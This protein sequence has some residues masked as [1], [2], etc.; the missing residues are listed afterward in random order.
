MMYKTA[1]LSGAPL[2]LESASDMAK[3]R[4]AVS[5]Q[6]LEAFNS[7]IATCKETKGA[8]H[9][10]MREQA[11]KQMEWR[12]E[13]RI[14]GTAPIDKMPS[15]SRASTLH[16]NDIHSAA[17]EF[18]EEIILFEDW[19]RQ[20]G[21]FFVPTHQPPGFRDDLNAEWEEI[22]TWWKVRTRPSAEVM[23]FF[24]EYVHDSRASFKCM[25]DADNETELRKIL[26]R[27]VRL[28]NEKMPVVVG[29]ADFGHSD[30]ALTQDQRRAADEYARTGRIPRMVNGGRESFAVSRAGYLRYRKT[31]GG[32]DEWLLS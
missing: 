13:R 29:K 9:H 6:T 16:Q 23:R 7:Y 3:G 19:L 4:F 22:A 27:W 8:I 12:I 5:A 2:K 24:D 15:F 30:A 31:Y 1:R 14:N 25:G 32:A 10:I 11:R 17:L 20:K 21:L 28:R 26:D 18:E